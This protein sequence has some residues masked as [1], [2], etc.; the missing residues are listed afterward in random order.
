[1][2]RRTAATAAAL[3]AVVLAAAC[4]TPAGEPGASPSVTTAPEAASTL[5]GL[6][7]PE[8]AREALEGLTVADPRPMTGY[9]RDHFPHWTT[10]DGCTVR[11]TVLRRDGTDVEVDDDCRPATG[12][13]H[14]PYEDADYTDPSDID[15]DHVV[16]LANAWR[17]GA[18]AWT[19]EEREAFANDLTRPQLIAVGNRINREKGDQSPDQWQPPEREF[20]CT[21]AL[22]WVAVKDAY[23]LTVTGPERAELEDMLGT[24]G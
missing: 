24:C 8:A 12:R 7:A 18:D 21:Y 9:S 2:V 4:D 17:S 3:L 19:E 20:W 23:G 14:S 1:M 10:E 22:A 5:P 15:I 16:P 11:E 6:P 13:W